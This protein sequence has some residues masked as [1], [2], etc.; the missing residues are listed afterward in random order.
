MPF[1]AGMLTEEQH[2]KPELQQAILQASWDLY[3][4][5]DPVCEPPDFT[6]DP[7]ID[8]GS[9]LGGQPLRIARRES[10]YGG[11]RSKL[12][13]PVI[14]DTEQGLFEH[15]KRIRRQAKQSWVNIRKASRFFQDKEHEPFGT[16]NVESSAKSIVRKIQR[17]T[18]L[19]FAEIEEILDDR[20]LG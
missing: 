12:A 7:G 10:S 11:G 17:E 15:I 8:L 2:P 1:W 14:V 20:G 13:T 18:G 3:F 5:D 4:R 6:R 9:I 16:K 19:S